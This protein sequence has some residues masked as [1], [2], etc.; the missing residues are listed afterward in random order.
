VNPR[1]DLA[2]FAFLALG[3]I[4]FALP[5]GENHSWATEAV[6]AAYWFIALV[7]GAC[8]VGFGWRSRRPHPNPLPKGR[9]G[10]YG[11]RG[12]PAVTAP[13]PFAERARVRGDSAQVLIA[14]SAAAI[15]ALV[16][17]RLISA[18]AHG[19]DAAGLWCVVLA[20]GFLVWRAME[21]V[22]HLATATG[23]KLLN[24]AAPALLGLWILYLWQVLTDGFSIPPVLLPA[25]SQIGGAI[26]S[27]ESTL[28]EDFFQTVV[29][30]VIP[31]YVIGNLAGFATAVLVDRFS[32]MKRGLLPIGNLFSSLP[33][34]GLAPIMVMWF[35]F[36]W[37]SKAAIVVVMTFFPMLANTITGLGETNQIER[38][39][40][41]TYAASYWQTLAEV[42][43]PAALPFVFNALKINSTLALI[44]AIVA[45]FFGGPTVGI[46]FRIT[47]EVGRMNITMVWAAIAVAAASGSVF[48]G[49]LALLE[50]RTTFWHPSFRQRA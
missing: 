36:D 39:L 29:K 23:S 7:L 37:Q 32:F 13:S 27:S 40:M 41:R 26:A 18:G 10:V 1:R 4:A 34:V 44:G 33:I 3:A 25:P 35:G 20:L 50:R 43:L 17:L 49:L 48:Y 22:A 45:E 42:R 16:P 15:G 24:L 30:S 8:L 47:A 31:G 5:L 28:V 14:L 38:D 46:G 21:R 9:G 19:A 12:V 11:K 2:S 6:T